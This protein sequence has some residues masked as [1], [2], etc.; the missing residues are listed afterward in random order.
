[1]HGVHKPIEK[2]SASSLWAALTGLTKLKRNDETKAIVPL[3][4]F[5]VWQRFISKALL[6]DMWLLDRE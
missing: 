3:I 1:M 2:K 6:E 5:A 4:S